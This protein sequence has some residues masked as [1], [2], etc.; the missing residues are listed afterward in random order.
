MITVPEEQVVVVSS[1]NVTAFRG[2]KNFRP[3][4]PRGNKVPN[5][6]DPD[7]KQT[8]N[9]VALAANLMF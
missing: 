8:N 2:G 3:V 7:T 1:S 5:P 6:L 9:N 4:T